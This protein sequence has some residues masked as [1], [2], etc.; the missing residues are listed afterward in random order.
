M[1]RVWGINWVCSREVANA[2]VVDG[3]GLFTENI[4]GGGRVNG[5]GG[6]V[7][8]VTWDTFAGSTWP[9]A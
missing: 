1:D 6:G 9:G 4:K 5:G 7:V 2:Q 3:K 8:A